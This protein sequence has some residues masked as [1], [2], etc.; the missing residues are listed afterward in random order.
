MYCDAIHIKGDHYLAYILVVPILLFALYISI[1]RF[2]RFKKDVASII[3]SYIYL[4]FGVYSILCLLQILFFN[5][6]Q[7]ST[8][9]ALTFINTLL[10]FSMAILCLIAGS[11]DVGLLD[12]KS[13]PTK[14]IIGISVLI[15]SSLVILSVF[16]VIG[17][18]YIST[19]LEIYIPVF[20]FFVYLSTQ[21]YHIKYYVGDI[22]KMFWLIPIVFNFTFSLMFFLNSIH[23]VNFT[24]MFTINTLLLVISM[25]MFSQYITISR[26][27]LHFGI[28]EGREYDV[29]MM[30]KS[31]KEKEKEEDNL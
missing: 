20:L 31:E 10:P 26:V 27:P 4:L 7:F 9:Y 13:K 19:L 29:V 30:L 24:S 11:V 2:I 5:T 3:Y 1:S 23:C 28:I 25:L 21:M 6:L 16:K 15:A 17:Y 14:F 22:K 18:Y 12:F 8:L